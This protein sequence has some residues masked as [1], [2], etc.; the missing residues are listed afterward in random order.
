MQRI[1]GPYD[2]KEDFIIVSTERKD[3][4][5]LL[6]GKTVYNWADYLF[7]FGC[8]KKDKNKKTLPYEK[9]ATQK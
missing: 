5:K 6:R 8:M 4:Y 3:T 1:Y 9:Q 2:N 7:F